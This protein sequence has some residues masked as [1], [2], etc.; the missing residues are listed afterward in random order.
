MK[1]RGLVGWGHSCGDGRGCGEGV[2]DVD[3]EGNKI[4][5]VKINK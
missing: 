2:R 4:W 1:F 3:W 5:S